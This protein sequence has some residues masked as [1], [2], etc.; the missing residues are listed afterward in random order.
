MEVSE[1]DWEGVSAESRARYATAM[2]KSA[3]KKRNPSSCHL[4]KVRQQEPQ[5]GSKV[6]PCEK[7]GVMRTVAIIQERTLLEAYPNGARALG[8]SVSVTQ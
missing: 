8:H 2:P 5:H 1:G 4:K 6:K 7:K 3:A